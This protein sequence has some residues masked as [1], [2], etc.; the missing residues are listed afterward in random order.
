MTF[1][2]ILTVIFGVIKGI[3]SRN[4]LHLFCYILAAVS[5]ANECTHTPGGSLE[6]KLRL[7]ASK[8]QVERIPE[9]LTKGAT[10]GP[11]RVSADD[12]NIY[13]FQ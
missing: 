13:S 8:G 5:M 4:C 7:A 9:L 10:F 12:R 11:D 6:D 3:I 1:Q 2:E